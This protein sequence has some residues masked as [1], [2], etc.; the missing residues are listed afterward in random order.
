MKTLISITHCALVITST[1]I[2]CPSD[3]CYSSLHTVLTS[4]P[5]SAALASCPSELALLSGKEEAVMRRGTYKGRMGNERGDTHTQSQTCTPTLLTASETPLTLPS[6]TFCSRAS[7]LVM[8][9]PNWNCWL[10]S[11][12]KELEKHPPV[13]EGEVDYWLN[14]VH[15]WKINVN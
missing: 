3:I 15:W 9:A 6:A 10:S 2:R 5:A 7:T 8:M 13:T 4:Q 11:A 14:P 1:A 12:E